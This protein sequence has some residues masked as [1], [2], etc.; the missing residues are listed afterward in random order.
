VNVNEKAFNTED[1][2]EDAY[3]PSTE[4]H[5]GNSEL[6]VLFLEY[7]MWNLEGSRLGDFLC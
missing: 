4:D 7:G 6:L 5:R 3:I 2:E 1:T